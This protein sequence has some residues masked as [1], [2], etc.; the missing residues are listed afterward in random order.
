MRA[1]TGKRLRCLTAGA[2]WFDQALEF[3]RAHAQQ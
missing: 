1:L 3:A 2:R